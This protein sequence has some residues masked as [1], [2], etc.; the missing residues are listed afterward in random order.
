L[1][2]NP[3]LLCARIRFYFFFSLSYPSL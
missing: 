3:H 1:F 2:C